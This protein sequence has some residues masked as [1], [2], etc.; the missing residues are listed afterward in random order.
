MANRTERWLKKR[1]RR[2]QQEARD[3]KNCNVY[4]KEGIFSDYNY[5]DSPAK[6]AA[7]IKEYNGEVKKLSR[8]KNSPSQYE[9]ILKM[10][11]LNEELDQLRVERKINAK[12]VSVV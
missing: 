1:A 11:K 10:R 5:G 2:L 12:E 4:E 3:K 9:G 6:R 7:K 8:E